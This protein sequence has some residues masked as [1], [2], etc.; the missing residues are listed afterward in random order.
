MDRKSALSALRVSTVRTQDTSVLEYEFLTTIGTSVVTADDCRSVLDE[1][2][3]RTLH[4]GL[5][6]V[7]V[8]FLQV[9]RVNQVEHIVHRH[10]VAQ[11]AAQH[12]RVVGVLTETVVY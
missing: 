4:S 9:E 1:F 5:P 8:I 10:I 12:L 3:Q 6:R 7:D 2:L 11:N